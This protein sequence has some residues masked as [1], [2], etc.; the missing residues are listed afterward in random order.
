MRQPRDHTRGRTRKR[1]FNRTTKRLRELESII[2][3][4]IPSGILPACTSSHIYLLQAAKLYRRDLLERKGLPTEAEV[5]DRL[6]VWHR[7]H[8]TPLETLRKIVA[9]A[10]RQPKIEDADTLGVQLSFTDADRTY[11]RI[12]TIGSC[13]VTKAQ[14]VERRKQKKRERDRQRAMR[15]RRQHGVMP[16][17]EYL[18]HSLSAQ[19]PW[20]AEGISRRTWQ[21]R[22]R[23]FKPE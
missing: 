14:R 10:M 4:R 16:R 2:S 23:F 18:K 12:T 11:L 9:Q 13:D 6:A 17:S 5:L 3:F 1:K 22:R 21:R 8:F 19:R 15:R 20:E 7:A